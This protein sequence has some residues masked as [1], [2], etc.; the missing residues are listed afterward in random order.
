MTIH[1][2][3]P[4]V[5]RGDEILTPEALAFVAALQRRV[6][7][8]PRRAARRPPVAPRR[9]RPHRPPRLPARD[10]RRP[11][12]RLD[13]RP[14]ARRP[15]GPAGRDHRADRPQDDDQRAQLRR[16]GLA[17]RPWRTPAPRTGA[18]SSAAR[19]TCT[20]RSAATSRFTS[21]EGK[22][23]AL[24]DR[25]RLATIVMRPARL[26]PR[27]AAPPGRR[28]ARWSAR[29]STSASTSSTT[30]QE[31]LDRGQ[32]AV[33]L[34]AEDGEPPRGAAVE[35]RV[36]LRPGASSASR[37]ARVRATVLIETIPAAFE[38]DEILYELR[39][40]ASGLNAGRWDYLFSIIKYF[41]DSGPDVRA[42]RPQRRSTMTSP[43]M[44]AYAELLVKTCHRRGAFAIGGMAAFIPSRRDAE[45]NAAAFAKVREDKE[46]EAGDGFDGSWVAHPDLVPV[47]REV[48][49]ARAR[50]PAQPARP[51]ARRRT[52][53]RRR[54]AR[55]RLRRRATITAGRSARQRRGGAALPRGVAARQRRGRA[56]TT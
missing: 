14:G 45:V 33:L 51:A 8:P 55:R 6:R 15:A 25:P 11:R 56:S 28:R 21:P 23:Y 19:S 30:P 40:H 50:R 53:D 38:M 48:F 54:P 37:T 34:P 18:T 41:R 4:A 7:S 36:H 3:G 24:R 47:C 20:T 42:A 43:F 44:R 52:R 26:A 12:R 29:W 39:D 17:G 46:R 2:T 1:V 9:G 22:S 10:G 16:P 32:R 13:G 49:D 31:L 35:R 5:E 27:R